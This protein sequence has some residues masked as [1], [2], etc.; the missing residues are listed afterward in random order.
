MV[1]TTGDVANDNIKQDL[2]NAGENDKV[3]VAEFIN[4]RLIGKKHRVP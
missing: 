2:M 3:L 4:K 1:L